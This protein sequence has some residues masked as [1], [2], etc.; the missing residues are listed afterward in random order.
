MV[1]EQL[2]EFIDTLSA[3]KF[4]ECT[5]EADGIKLYLKREETVVRTQEIQTVPAV[6]PVQSEIPK[7]ETVKDIVSPIVG[8][9][10][11]APSPDADP[12]VKVGDR[13]EK[14][15]VIGIVEA[16]KLMNEIQS[17]ISGVVTHIYAENG[18]GVEYG[19]PLIGVRE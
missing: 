4:T 19:Q 11:A 10:Y 17:D 3:S 12:F 13:V 16:M 7:D 6:E 15:Q 2:L 18:D 5:Y 8:V 1:Y 9:F 14:G